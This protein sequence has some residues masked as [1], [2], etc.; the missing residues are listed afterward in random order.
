[1]TLA[2]PSVELA[3]GPIVTRAQVQGIAWRV[4]R[5]ALIGYCLFGLVTHAHTVDARGRRDFPL[6]QAP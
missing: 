1:M 4:R 5:V 2:I 3:I 6:S